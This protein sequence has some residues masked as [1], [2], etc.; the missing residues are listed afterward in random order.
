METDP[1][2][3]GAVRARP[4]GGVWAV[5]A[6][7]FFSD[8]GH[9][10]VTSVLP[11]F[12]TSVLGG[13]AA[14]LGLIDGVSDALAGIAKIA[15]GPPADDPGRRRSIAT[16]GYLVTAVATAAIG[17]TTAV[18]QVAGLRATAWMARGIRSPAR[19][20]MLAS[21]AKGGYGRAY[22]IERAGDNLGAV[23]GPL[24]AAV[25]VAWLGIRPTMWLAVVPGV[26][27]AVAITVAARSARR[28]AGPAARRRAR[29]ALRGLAGT[30]IGRP[31]VPIVLFECGNLATTLLI[32][33]ATDALGAL[34]VAG[35]A[36]V[37]VLLYAGHNAVAAGAA[38]VGGAW[39]DR[40]DPRTVFAAGAAVYLVAYSLLALGAPSAPVLVVAF[41]LAGAGI[42]FAETAE[43]AM[44]A[45]ILPDALRGSGFGL[46]GAVQAGGDVVATVVAGVLYT[47][48]GPT[49]AFGYAAG[50]MLLAVAATI[51]VRGRRG[52]SAG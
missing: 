7:S 13:S 42:G 25:F 31:L 51:V 27:A 33:R 32:L 40:G 49:A 44:V 3:D 35:A 2:A 24:M 4:G 9:E 28:L 47:I 26:L 8:A 50:W 18:W 20:A 12:L 17:L 39:I 36:S 16:G 46:L 10:M 21:L 14:A 34:G 38:A 1:P 52:A 19:D 37:A 29:F 23:A 43:S 22:G 15:G 45:G 5:G 11:A 48:A 41:V 30:G 6:A